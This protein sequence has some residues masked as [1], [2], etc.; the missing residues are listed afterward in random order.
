[1]PGRRLRCFAVRRGWLGVNPVAQ[2]AGESRW[3]VEETQRWRVD[4][5]AVTLSR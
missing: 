3:R 5:E 4:R 1:M 2:L